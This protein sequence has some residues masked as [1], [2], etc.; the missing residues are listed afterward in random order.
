MGELD[1]LLEC[2]SDVG[3]WH[4]FLHRSG[5]RTDDTQYLADR[6]NPWAG[7]RHLQR[8]ARVVT[9][10]LRIDHHET[11]APRV[12]FTYERQARRCLFVALD[13]DVLE[14]IAETGFD[15]AFIASIDFE[16][17]GDGALLANVAVGLNQHHPR[18][19]AELASSRDELFER[20]QPRFQCR[21]IL[22]AVPDAT[23]RLVV[24]TARGRQ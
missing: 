13:D 24:R 19:V 2:F 14:Q 23:H 20:G 22:L 4:Y 9:V 1:R 18:R 17:I 21:E 12:V 15:R 3:V 11:A 10:R 8:L 16:V 6:N 5:M 7:T